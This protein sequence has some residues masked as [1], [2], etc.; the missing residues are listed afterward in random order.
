MSGNVNERYF[1]IGVVRDK[2]GKPKFGD[3]DALSPEYKM[4]YR[5]ML[6]DEDKAKLTPEERQKLGVQD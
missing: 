4:A 2:H 1:G 5:H 6:T 3:L